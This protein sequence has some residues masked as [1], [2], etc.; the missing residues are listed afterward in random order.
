VAGPVA[1]GVA[2]GWAIIGRIAAV[3]LIVLIVIDA[4]RRLAPT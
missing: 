4:R 3:V 2:L 1:G